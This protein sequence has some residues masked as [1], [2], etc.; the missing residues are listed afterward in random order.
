MGIPAV[1]SA[2]IPGGGV[3]ALLGGGVIGLGCGATALVLAG[4]LQLAK[5][6][7]TRA[8]L[9]EEVFGLPDGSPLKRQL[10]QK[11]N[12]K[13]RP[14]EH[15]RRA[16]SAQEAKELEAAAKYLCTTP[17]AS[18]QTQLRELKQQRAALRRQPFTY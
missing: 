11:T 3:E 14:I 10:A 4:V 6:S 5:R 13:I 2:M 16:T 8:I 17:G 1:F 9:G 15:R 12:L 7:G 18:L